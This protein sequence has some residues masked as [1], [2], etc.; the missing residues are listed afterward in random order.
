MN[1]SNYRP[2]IDGLRAIAVI[3]VIFFHG[4]LGVSGGFCG[5]DVFFVI[6]GY[7]ITK[8]ILNDLA[9]KKFSMLAFWERRIRRIFPA[10]VVVMLACL[11]AGWFLLL[12]YGY[13]VLAQST[14]ALLCFAS[15]I[16]FWRTISYWSPAAEENPLLHTWSLSLEEQFYILVPVLVAGLYRLKRPHFVPGAFGIIVLASFAASIFG[17]RAEPAGAFFLLPSRAWELGM[18]ALLCFLPPIR[19]QL[20]REVNSFLGLFGILFS[21]FFLTSETPFPGLAAL[22]AVLGAAL[23][24]W[25]GTID[26]QN[27]LPFVCRF[28]SMQPL[29]GV[30]LIS[31][32]LYLWHWPFFAF[33]RYLFGQPAP[34]GLSLLYMGLA[35]FLSYLSW[36]YVEQPFRRKQFAPT[37]KALFLFFGATSIVILLFSGIVYLKGGLPFRIP[38]TALDFDRVKGNEEFVPKAKSEFAGGGEVLSFGVLGQRPEILVWGDSHAGVMLHA[39]DA[40][41][42]KLEISG[43]AVIRGGTP[44]TFGWSGASQG[45]QEDKD[46]L[47]TGLEVENLLKNNNIQTVFLIFRWSYYVRRDPPLHISRKP[48]EGFDEAFLKTVDSMVRRG[49]QVV[50]FEEVPIFKN[51][52][53]RGMA[54]HHWIGTP[55][56]TLTLGEHT[57]FQQPYQSVLECIRQNHPNVTILDPSH[58]IFEG[59][60]VLYMAPDGVLLYRDEHHWT[61]IAA[62]KISNRI[63][64]ILQQP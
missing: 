3:G 55:K 32:S 16:Q 39:I 4:N 47:N 17:V 31:Y 30:G 44:P 33:H 60:Q 49:V 62:M 20:W 41:C 15:N 18:G 25:S 22:P 53:A 45:S 46:S 36:M 50:I 56:P 2:D 28:L 37:K 54:L 58:A 34:L 27:K 48:I 35:C 6:S 24:I 59:D 61:K 40:A 13:L 52:I 11:V 1:Q 12:P 14:I 29:V 63:F 64:E 7:L 42:R 21:F 26:K 51:H 23:V 10:L 57:E 5:V 43:V 19:A 8:I 9:N 38:P